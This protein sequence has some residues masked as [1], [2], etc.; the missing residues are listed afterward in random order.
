[1][2]K[3]LDK[4]TKHT[5]HQWQRSSSLKAGSIRHQQTNCLDL[6]ESQICQE[7]EEKSSIT[8]RYT[9][10]GPKVTATWLQELEQHVQAPFWAN[11]TAVN[12]VP[13][14]Q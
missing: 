13:D 8:V 9:K 7:A 11:Q 1:M 3:R 5:Q 2:A 6:A 12:T 4:I 10:L 14:N